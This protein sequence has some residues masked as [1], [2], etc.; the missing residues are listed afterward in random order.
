MSFVRAKEIPPH[1][2]NWYDYEVQTIHQKGKVIQ[3]YIRYLGKS[4][5]HSYL[6][7]SHGGKVLT[8]KP[9]EPKTPT[10][11]LEDKARIPKM[12]TH[13]SKIASCWY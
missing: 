4:G 8:S 10:T 3:K 11:P 6:P 2:G 9:I 7:S 1:S 5:S 13:A 12:K